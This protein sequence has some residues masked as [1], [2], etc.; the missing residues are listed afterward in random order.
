MGPMVHRKTWLRTGIEKDPI[1]GLS[2]TADQSVTLDKLL[3]KASFSSYISK[4]EIIVP[5]SQGLLGKLRN[6]I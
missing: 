5:L 4:M 1:L 3:Q 6:N 2:S